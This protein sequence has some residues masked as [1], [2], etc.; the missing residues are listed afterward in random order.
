MR[1]DGAQHRCLAGGQGDV[2]PLHEG[3]AE[4]LGAGAVVAGK[5]VL[6]QRRTPATVCTFSPPT[7]RGR[8]GR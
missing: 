3:V 4:L 8:T 7:G 6:L 2:G 5:P 1:L